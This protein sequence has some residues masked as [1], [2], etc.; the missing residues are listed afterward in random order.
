VNPVTPLVR[1]KGAEFGARTAIVPGLQSSLSLWRLD[2]ASELLFIGDAG[3]TEAS[4]PSRRTGVEWAN[5][6]QARD[7]LV[8]DVDFAVSRARFTDDVPGSGN[9][10]PG[11][12]DK[13]VSVGTSIANADPWSGGVRLRYFG[14]RP[15]VEDNS[16]RSRSS[17]L[18]NANVGY[19]FEKRVKL[20]FEVFNLANVKVNDIE[21]F[22]ESQVQGEA[23]PVSDHHFHPAEPRSYRLM[24]GYRF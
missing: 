6:W 19:K 4:R 20:T 13:T 12:I 22:Y 15:L 21:Y 17:T 1:A 5:Y 3:T 9:H 18:V 2:L 11:A 8:V 23:A 10:I 7:W 24:L 14:P 16:A